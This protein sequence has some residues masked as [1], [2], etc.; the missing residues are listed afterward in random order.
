MIARDLKGAVPGIGVQAT[1]PSATDALRLTPGS[2]D[3]RIKIDVSPIAHGAVRPPE[4]RAVVAEVEENLGRT[5]NRLTSDHIWRY[6]FHG[7]GSWKVA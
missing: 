3:C 1:D 7:A 4:T 5:E 2:H 6:F